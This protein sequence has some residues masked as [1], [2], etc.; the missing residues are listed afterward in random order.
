[1]ATV[2]C[3][4]HIMGPGVGGGLGVGSKFGQGQAEEIC[5]GSADWIQ[6]M[7]I[8]GSD[9]RAESIFYDKLLLG[10]LSSS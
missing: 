9:R 5:W 4:W 1:M 7:C 3:C 8:S 10:L 6:H 2:S